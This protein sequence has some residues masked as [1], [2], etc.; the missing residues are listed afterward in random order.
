M[1]L[2]WVANGSESMV[3]I[4]R[5]LVLME[6][7]LRLEKKDTRNLPTTALHKVLLVKTSR[8]LGF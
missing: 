6:L 2:R 4:R 1:G 7:L 8:I 5:F 3:G